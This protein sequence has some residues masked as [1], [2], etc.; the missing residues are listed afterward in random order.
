M[1]GGGLSLPNTK[2]SCIPLFPDTENSCRHLVVLGVTSIAWK[3][4][5][6]GGV[7]RSMLFAVL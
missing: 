2:Y 3:E 1:G 4:L 6:S 7:L 5:V